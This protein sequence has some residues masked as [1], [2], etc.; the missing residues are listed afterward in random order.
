MYH[1]TFSYKKRRKR[2]NFVW[3]SFFISSTPLVSQLVQ[4]VKSRSLSLSTWVQHFPLLEINCKC[5]SASHGSNFQP[6]SLL[7]FRLF[8]GSG[9]SG[10]ERNRE[11]LACLLQLHWKG[12]EFSVRNS[13]E[14][15]SIEASSCWMHLFTTFPLLP[16]NSSRCES[17]ISLGVIFVGYY[18]MHRDALMLVELFS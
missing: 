6:Y 16:F 2:F 11:Q 1:D 14:V 10:F 18:N 12:L 9:S 3:V 7:I 4:R 15:D 5:Q 13:D 17:M 8:G